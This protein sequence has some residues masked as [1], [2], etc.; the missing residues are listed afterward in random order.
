MYAPGINRWRW[1]LRAGG[2]PSL[3]AWVPLPYGSNR[4]EVL[5]LLEAGGAEGRRITG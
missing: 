2:L 1:I 3:N 5:L 4:I